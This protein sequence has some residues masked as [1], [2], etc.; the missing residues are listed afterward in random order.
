MPLVSPPKQPSG[1]ASP[2]TVDAGR[3][4]Q[5]SQAPPV[6][7]DDHRRRL[8]A[9]ESDQDGGQDGDRPQGG[10]DEQ[11]ES[12]GEAEDGHGTQHTAPASGEPGDGRRIR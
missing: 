1:G 11:G 9:M 3:I 7:L 4:R 2:S 10:G 12:G 8:E 5:A 6:G